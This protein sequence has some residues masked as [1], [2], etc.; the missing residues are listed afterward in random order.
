[1]LTT[2][3]YNFRLKKITNTNIMSVQTKTDRFLTWLKTAKLD[4]KDYQVSGMEWVL[5]RELDPQ[6]G[7]P[8]GFL[9]DEMGLGK[10]ILMVGAIM[11]NFKNH[12]LMAH[13]WYY[14]VIY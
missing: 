6:V 10:T 7:T 3:H 5:N 14:Q 8:G 11:S 1:M 12:N 2:T 13:V 4:T 9:C